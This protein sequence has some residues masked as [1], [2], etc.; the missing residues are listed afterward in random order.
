ML[1]NFF[2][3]GSGA[4]FFVDALA[5]PFGRVGAVRVGTVASAAAQTKTP[6]A[7]SRPASKAGDRI[8]ENIPAKV[9]SARRSVARAKRTRGVRLSSLRP[10]PRP[11]ARRCH[12]LHARGTSA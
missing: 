9:R 4:T 3:V 6:A 5:G 2:A 10:V 7:K 1:P 11:D 12:P 8:A